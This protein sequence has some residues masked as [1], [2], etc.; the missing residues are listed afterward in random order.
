DTHAVIWYIYADS[1]LSAIAKTAIDSAAQA[2][3]Q[4]GVSAITLV[5]M[6]YLVE[7]GRISSESFSILATSLKDAENVF[8]EIPMNLEIARMITTIDAAQI[9]DMP[10]RIIA[11][12]A[13][14][15]GVP[16]ISRDSQIQLSN[17]T[18]IW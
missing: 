9:P 15:P 18:T 11:A 4:I 7:K 8:T 10:D 14:D 5:E 1:R 3:D 16:V 17:V 12:T 2:G 13:Q 6:V